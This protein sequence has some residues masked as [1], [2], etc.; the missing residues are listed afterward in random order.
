MSL[1]DPVTR[2]AEAVLAGEVVAGPYVIWAC[3]RH[4][5]DLERDDIYLDLDAVAVH[6][7]FFKLLKHWKGRW[8]GRPITLEPWQQFIQG[9]I[10][11][12]KRRADGL[13]RFRES[14]VFVGRKNG[15]TTMGAG[16]GLYGLSLDG[17]QGA[18]IYGAATKRDQAKIVWEDARMM[19]KRSPWLSKRINCYTSNISMP[20]MA[21][22]FEPLSR[23]TKSL[24]GLNVHIAIADE[25]H[26]W[27]DRLM[28]SQLEDSMGAREQPLIYMITT[29]GSNPESICYEKYEH[30]IN[31]LDPA[32]DEY[33]DDTL[34]IY[35]ATVA[36]RTATDDPIQWA[37]AN[38]NLGISKSLEYMEQQFAKA[39]QLPTRMVDFE[40]KHL[41]IWA[42]AAD[43]WLNLDLWKRAEDADLRIADF[44]GQSCYLGLDLAE[45]NDMS[46]LVALFPGEDGVWR[47]FTWFWCPAE[48][49]LKRSRADKVPYEQWERSGH[50]TA[51]PGSATD[52]DFIEAEIRQLIERFDVKEF[53]FDRWKSAGLVQNLMRDEVVTCV[54]YGQGYKD[55]SPA[56]KEVERRLLSEKLRH[57]KSPI[58]SWNAANAETARDPSGNIKL[59]KKSYRKR[60]DGLAAL[61]NAIG[62]ALINNEDGGPSVYEDRGVIEL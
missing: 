51:T 30:A 35:L 32:M 6:L 3:E 24:D 43:R 11:G 44:E 23:D 40:I 20:S 60:I 49:I 14:D 62:V 16:T 28:W 18:E 4:F 8:S 46:A 47:Y 31:V 53:A 57:A 38:P 37:M 58:L 21:S 9:S 41:N 1:P 48:D 12:W 26:A 13:R 34:F 17:E 50:L 29:M 56:L 10:F 5:R 25:V 61:A 15:K 33:F 27:E 2:Y 39:Q 45:V 42:H 55:A 52:F 36:D 22:K 54:P 7:D 19:V 59:V